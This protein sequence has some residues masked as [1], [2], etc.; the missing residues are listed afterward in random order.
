MDFND[1]PDQAAFRA[2]VRAFLD[3]NAPVRRHSSETP[4]GANDDA[5]AVAK[6]WQKRLYDAGWACIAW[7]EAF[8]GRGATPI[9]SVIWNQEVSRYVTPDGTFIIGQGMCAPTMMAYA[10]EAQ[11]ERFL[12]K[13]ASGEEVW[14]QLFSEPVAGSDLAGIKTRA[15]RDGDDWVINGQKVWT[16]GAHYSDYGLLITRTDPSVPK[17]KGLT[18][19]FLDMRSA[20]VDVRP[21]KQINGNQDFNEVYFTDVR[22]PDSQRLGT[23]GEGW[24]VALVTLMNERLAVGGGLS[25]TVMD[26]FTA[27]RNL[28]ADDGPAI[29]N[30]AYREHLADWYCREMGLKYTSY[31]MITALSKG[32]DPGPEASISKIVVAA[33]NN[34]SANFALDLQDYGGILDAEDAGFGA[35][36]QRQFLR[37]PANRIEGGSDEILRN[38]I[39]ERVLG[40][41]PD[42]RPDKNVPFSEVPQSSVKG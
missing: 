42:I 37:S 11:N 20:G 8:G 17:H 39:S 33:N 19:F 16:S 25:N 23:P 41:P 10:T 36:F 15:I 35:Q 2:D 22:I 30:K 18:M 1:S 34:E 28:D 38:I 24:K 7:P 9:Q 12:P 5:I 31:R 27:A 4:Y 40:M 32:E 21:I 29:E 14:C 13:I 3:A 6:D 26:V